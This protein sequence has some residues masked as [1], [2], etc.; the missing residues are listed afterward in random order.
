MVG[1]SNTVYLIY[2]HEFIHT[3]YI[4]LYKLLTMYLIEGY[5]IVGKAVMA[6]IWQV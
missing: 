6:K 5:H 2:D 3:Y 1:V 4:L